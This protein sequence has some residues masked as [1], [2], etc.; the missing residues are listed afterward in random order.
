MYKLSKLLS[1]KKTSRCDYT[2]LLV[3]C[4]EDKKDIF[5]SFCVDLN[6]CAI[7]DVAASRNDVML[8]TVMF[9]AEGYITCPQGQT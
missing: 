3:L 2:D 9:T 1:N 7:S 6:P 8:R 5:K 4:M